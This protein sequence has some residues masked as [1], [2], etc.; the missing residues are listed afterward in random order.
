[1]SSWKKTKRKVYKG[2]VIL[3]GNTASKSMM[4][5]LNA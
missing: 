2:F 4:T 3:T 1:M 5:Q